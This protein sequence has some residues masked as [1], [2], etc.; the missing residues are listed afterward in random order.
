[1]KQ[2]YKLY[3]VAL[4]LVG[5][6][7]MMTARA[8]GSGKPTLAVFVVGMTNNTDGDNLATQVAA[9]LNRN[10]RYNVLLSADNALANKLAELRTAHTAGNNIDRTALA[11]WGRANGV[12]TICLV[13]DDIKGNDHMFSAQLIDAKGN[14]LEGKGSYIRTNVGS[15]DLPQASLV[16]ARQLDG[17]GRMHSTPTPAQ[18]YPDKLGI[19]MVRVLGGTFTMGCTSEQVSCLATEKPTHSVTVSSF[20]IGRF[21]VTQAQ[22]K[23][24]M[25]GI[26]GTTVADAGEIYSQKGSSCG[27]V[28]CDDQQPAENFDW[29]EAVTFCNELSRKAGLQ[30]VYTITGT[31]TSKTVTWDVNKRGYR[32]PTEA[33]WEYAARGCKGD[34]SA[35]NATCENLLYSGSS[36]VNEVGWHNG[37]S[38]ATTHPVGQKMPNGLGIYD[39]S[40]NVW[41]WCYDWYAAYSSAAVANPKGPDTGSNCVIRGYG[42]KDAP[43]SLRVAARNNWEVRTSRDTS[44]GL[45]V[46][47]P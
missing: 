3:L 2:N 34:G 21:E 10:S 17:S 18:S 33:E 43:I 45:R 25:T 22:W 7:G 26:A 39:M 13:V 1:M 38:S 47:L 41:E 11:K 27:N 5:A 8:Q 44:V 23:A 19:E 40:G 14:K 28:P 29:F 9:E 12:S 20:S 32:L 42:W 46:V 24:V 30:E 31:G 35:N 36:N 15:T 37:N 4:L 6:T 16:L